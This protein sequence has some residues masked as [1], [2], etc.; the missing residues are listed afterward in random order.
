MNTEIAITNQRNKHGVKDS[1]HQYRT[2][3]GQHYMQWTSNFND[4]TVKAYRAAGVR[5]RV[6]KS[7][8]YIRHADVE[9]ALQL[10][11]AL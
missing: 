11:E 8:M 7:E 5:V 9:K 4:D 2:I 10:P 3:N 1:C 6:I